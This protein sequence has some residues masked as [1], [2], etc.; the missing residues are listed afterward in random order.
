MALWCTMIPFICGTYHGLFV[1]TEF[2]SVFPSDISYFDFRVRG[3][4]CIPAD[5]NPNLVI[6]F[7]ISSGSP[8]IMVS[9]VYEAV[10]GTRKGFVGFGCLIFEKDFN[11][12]S[13]Q[14]GILKAIELAQN[15][16]SYFDGRRISGRPQSSDGRQLDL[17]ELPLLDKSELYGRLALNIHES[18]AITQITR[19]VLDAIEQPWENFEIVVN[20]NGGMTHDVLIE[21]LKRQF[22][23]IIQEK[24][25]AE[26]K[27]LHEENKK[28]LDDELK[29]KKELSKKEQRHFLQQIATYGIAVIS[30]AALSI[31]I[32]IML[33]KGEE[34]TKQKSIT[35]AVW[36]PEAPA[37]N[38]MVNKNTETNQ[39]ASN[40][41][42]NDTA[43]I[44][45][46]CNIDGLSE[47]SMKL[48]KVITDLPKLSDCLQ[49]SE[50]LQD[51]LLKD[52]RFSRLIYTDNSNF[53]I[54]ST[55]LSEYEWRI[56]SFKNL[57]GNADLDGMLFVNQSGETDLVSTELSIG[58]SFQEAKP[59][60][61]CKNA[62][63][64]PSL[65]PNPK[66]QF[67]YFTTAENQYQ[68]AYKVFA[69]GI[70]LLVEK[71]YQDIRVANAE[72]DDLEK[73]LV[74]IK[75]NVSQGKTPSLNRYKPTNYKLADNSCIITLDE[76]DAHV[77]Q[78]TIS[79][80]KE[81]TKKLSVENFI[82]E[83]LFQYKLMQETRIEIPKLGCHALPELFV[84]AKELNSRKYVISDVEGLDRISNEDATFHFFPKIATQHPPE[85]QLPQSDKYWKEV[86]VFDKL[87]DA[88][89][90]EL[91]RTPFAPKGY[92]PT[93]LC[94]IR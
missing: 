73:D 30:L 50:P 87:R 25:Q 86:V 78:N 3:A 43:Q 83:Q 91:D 9:L 36:Q 46:P 4:R 20:A 72:N 21:D 17:T 53:N 37:E 5:Q 62:F 33:F 2:P 55:P 57:M 93:E 85:I 28:K 38:N 79:E 52:M 16:E 18:G 84:F 49:L 94:F 63:S 54:L 51:R 13:I 65:I 42:S 67:Y 47:D 68:L 58:V 81:D 92:D 60:L 69:H 44:V 24:L 70:L 14:N 64:D 8:M 80:K 40:G 75:R 15:S 6:R 88:Y 71:I 31:F 59:Q 10:E 35:P 7:N 12:R 77:L 19:L 23:L 1:Q 90:D 61:F 66:I 41:A 29:R 56:T 32:L 76:Q 26:K 27:R 48:R 45:E 22:N 39:T 34:E 89:D 74:K 11:D 82:S